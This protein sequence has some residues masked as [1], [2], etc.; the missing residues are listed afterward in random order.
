VSDGISG[1][2]MSSERN[3][4]TDPDQLTIYP[5]RIKKYLGHH[6]ASWFA[7]LTVTL[8]GAGDTRLTGPVVDQAA[9][10]AALKRV[11]DLGTPVISV[12]PVA[13]DRTEE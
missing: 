9:L 3:A 5:I 12:N 2:A 11:R 8:D 1:A 6:W 10:H 7:G 4:Q 13:P